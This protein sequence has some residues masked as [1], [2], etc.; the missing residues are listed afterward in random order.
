MQNDTLTPA[1]SQHINLAAHKIN[2][3]LTWGEGSIVPQAAYAADDAQQALLAAVLGCIEPVAA[4]EVTHSLCT[5]GRIPVRLQDGQPVPVREQMVGADMVSAFYV[6]ETLGAA[7]YDTPD[8]PVV[9]RVQAV[10]TF[11]KD[12]GIAACSHVG[13]GAG[14]SFVAITANVVRFA[15]NPAYQ[16]RQQELLPAGIYDPALHDQMIQSNQTRLD[17]N[18][19]EGLDAQVFLDVVEGA[20]GK[21][22]ISELKDD[23]RGVHGHVEE[24]IIRLHTPGY[25][26]NETRLAA[27]TG[28]REVFGVND[29][30][31][32][33]LAR[34][35][36]RGSERDYRIAYMA[37]EDFADAG[38]AT[39]AKDL[40][41]YIVAAV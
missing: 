17:S 2:D 30:R 22:A 41:T 21:H 8:A 11:L 10:A 3:T 15:Q 34:L 1:T 39:L 27:I 12:N 37:L 9:E 6:A 5:D 19:Y 29:N 24:M 13:C 7:F 4:Q 36:A 31:I 33:R 25:A 23:G 18:A 35:F 16:A 40:P 26:I 38:H 28:G 32:E 14:A 20:C